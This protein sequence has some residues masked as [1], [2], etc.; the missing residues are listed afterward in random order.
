MA[1][2]GFVVVEEDY[3]GANSNRVML[4]VSYATA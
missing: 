3:D 1:K 4:D 2:M